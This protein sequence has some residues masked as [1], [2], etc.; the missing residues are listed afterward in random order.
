MDRGIGYLVLLG[1][2]VVG[3]LSLE[4]VAAKPDPYV[5]LDRHVTAIG[6]WAALDAVRT[7]H[8]KGTLKIEGAAL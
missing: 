6:G 1:A 8:S 4:L 2:L 7:T 3:V 5:I